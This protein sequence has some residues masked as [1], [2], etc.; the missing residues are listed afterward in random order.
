MPPEL[1]AAGGPYEPGSPARDVLELLVNRWTI[2]IV[3]TL[4]PGPLRFSELR[5]ASGLGA[6]V[7]TRTLRSLEENGLVSREVFAEVPPRVEY[8]LTDLGSTLCPVVHTIRDWA[9][10]HANDLA[11]ARD[12][13]RRKANKARP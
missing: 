13:F 6:Q 8:Q 3:N 4:Q 5:A 11:V 2:L 12:R 1:E 10:R 9:E 7:L